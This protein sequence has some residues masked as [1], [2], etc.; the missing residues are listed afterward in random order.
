L[1]LLH[2][3]IR[4]LLTSC[5]GME[6]RGELLCFSNVVRHGERHGR[7][8][9][10][11][12]RWPA[13]LPQ[14]PASQPAWPAWPPHRARAAPAI[15]AKLAPIRQRAGGC[16][17][18]GSGGCTQEGQGQRGAGGVSNKSVRQ[19]TAAFECAQHSGP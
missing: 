7:D 16:A 9:R 15:V 11:Q 2:S 18:G 8:K 19:G 17:C 3:W 5:R 10:G 13:P 1:G 6:G 4:P 12:Q 14:Q